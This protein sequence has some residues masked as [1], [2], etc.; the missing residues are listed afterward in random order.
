M[1]LPKA[2]EL[3]KMKNPFAVHCL[4]RQRIYVTL[5]PCNE[6]AKLL[7]QAGITEVIYAE[8]GVVTLTACTALPRWGGLFMKAEW[9]LA[10]GSAIK[11]PI[12]KTIAVP[13]ARSFWNRLN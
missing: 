3:L 6:C 2:A 8:V 7:I 13:G 9:A 10:S 5:F 12:R 1:H 11:K 4:W